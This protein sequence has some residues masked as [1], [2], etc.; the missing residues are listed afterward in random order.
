[1]HHFYARDRQLDS[2]GTIVTVQ[3]EQVSP[4]QLLVVRTLA[5]NHDNIS[6]SEGVLF[7]ITN[8]G[9]V[10][11]V[12]QGV[13]TI[14]AGFVNWAGTLVVPEGWWVEGVYAAAASTEVMRLDIT[15]YICSPHDYWGQVF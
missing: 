7:R 6:T 8:G 2:D 9:R 10:V 13:P 3:D 4:N 15:G 12:H 14:T 11:N 5:G 1:M